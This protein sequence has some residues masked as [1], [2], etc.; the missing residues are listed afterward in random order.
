MGRRE[1]VMSGQSIGW[2]CLT[3]TRSWPGYLGFGFKMLLAVLASTI[4][5]ERTFDVEE[6]AE[7]LSES[8][9]SWLGNTDSW[10]GRGLVGQEVLCHGQERLSHGQ[11]GL[12]YYQKVLSHGQE[13]T[14]LWVRKS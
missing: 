4:V 11:E 13:G 5:G 6:K 10:S 1:E 3:E 14:D 2:F 8:T 7:S 9:A 12:S